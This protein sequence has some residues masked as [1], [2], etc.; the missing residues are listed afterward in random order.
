MLKTLF[1]LA[2]PN[3]ITSQIHMVNFIEIEQGCL[4]DSKINIIILHILWKKNPIC[5]SSPFLKDCWLNWLMKLNW[6][7]RKS[8]IDV[9]INSRWSG[10]KQCKATVYRS[11]ESDEGKQ[12]VFLTAAVGT[13]SQFCYPSLYRQPQLS[14]WPPNVNP[15]DDADY[16]LLFF[17][18]TLELITCTVMSFGLQENSSIQYFIWVSSQRLCWFCYLNLRLL[19][20]DTLSPFGVKK[21]SA[22]FM[23]KEII[24]MCNIKL[25]E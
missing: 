3:D 9:W 7:I 17:Y 25:T 5:N 16:A 2:F 18:G 1:N 13:S 22:V 21:I 19:A 15:C 10:T 8:H 4:K 12:D 11:L 6:Q 14:L 20:P 23:C 24:I